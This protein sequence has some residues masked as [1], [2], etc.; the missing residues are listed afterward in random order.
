MRHIVYLLLVANLVYLGWN[1]F[2]GRSMGD[3]VSVM[4]PVPEGA[5]P[6]VTLK[7]MQQ[8]AAATPE[9]AVFD[10]TPESAS[11]DAT[12]EPAAFEMLTAVE[13]PG[14]GMPACLALGPFNILDEV[15]AVSARL[16]ELGLQPRQR[17]AEVREENGYWIYLPSMG[18]A[19][20]LEV[21]RTLDE[22]GDKE[23][24]I[25]KD[26]VIS[27]GTFKG[28][29]RAE[30][31]LQQVRKLGLDAILEARFRTRDSYWLE[32]HMTPSADSGLSAILGEKPQ[33]QMHELACF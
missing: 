16:D 9:P 8:G 20:A 25:G 22:K 23:Y 28:I 29:E 4:P 12:P 5:K 31:R 13:P 26:N 2:P 19:A 21:A 30:V 10:A 32:F 24:F 7:E 3:P 14:A 27:L 18:R 17:I 6:L 15:R 1:L 11:L 33:L